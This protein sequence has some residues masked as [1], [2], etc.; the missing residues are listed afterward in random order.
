[1][2]SRLFGLVD[3][4]FRSSVGLHGSEGGDDEGEDIEA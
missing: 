2:L 3:I 1:M 4:D